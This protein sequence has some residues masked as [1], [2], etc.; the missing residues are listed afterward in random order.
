MMR[1]LLFASALLV[2]MQ[3][4]AQDIDSATVRS[5][6]DYSLSNGQAYEW[7]RHLTESIG[8]RLS[9]S[10]QAAQ[11]VSYTKEVL[12]TLGADTVYLQ[13][14]MVPHWVRNNREELTVF[15]NGK[16]IPLTICALGGSIA[17][18]EKGVRADVIEV[19]S[20]DE[21]DALGEAGV[22]GKIVFFNGP[23]N[24]KYV[25]TF[26]AYGEAGKYR[27]SAAKNAA[28]YGAVATITRSLTL[29]MDDVPHTGAMGYN[30]TIKKIPCCA[31]STM[32]AEFLSAELKR[33]PATQAQ[34][35]LNCEMLPDVLSYNV[36]AEIRGSLFPDEVI[37]VGGHLDSWDT[38]KGA[39]D[40]GAGCVQ[41]MELIRMFHDLGIHPKRTV[42]VVLFMNE[43][44]GLRGGTK[45]AEFAKASSQKYLAAI[46][47]DEG[48]F[49]PR[50]FSF[51]GTAAQERKLRGFAPL[52]EPYGIYEWVTG[53]GGADISELGSLGTL[54]IGL[55]P[56][57]QRYFDYHHTPIDTFDKVNRRELQLGAAAIASLAYLLANYGIE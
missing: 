34:L 5:F 2:T 37:T 38:G 11:A 53:G 13:E 55:S 43:E 27:Y 36:V 14:V 17:T 33:N 10:P 41:S 26:Q 32:D 35:V 31:I 15:S 42:R 4:S 45:Y 54:M 24:Q 48:G 21:L 6:Y 1:R 23:M 16:K 44:N 46:E 12:Q 39:H 56:D 50:G 28:Q 25:N 52:F 47:S 9:G 51:S 3:C 30:D 8:G 40:D 7:L 49:A 19:K 29:S 18:P 22:K 20:F 57:S